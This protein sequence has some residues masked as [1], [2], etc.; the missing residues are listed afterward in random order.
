MAHHAEL[1]RSCL[2]AIGTHSIL[3]VGAYAGDLTRV[4]ADWAAHS[5]ARV[6]AV[7][8]S[9]QPGL[10]KLAEHHPGVELVRQTSLQA[11]PTVELPDVAVIDGDHNYYTVS[12]ELRILGERAPGAQLPLL[13]FHDVC[14]PHG[15]RDDYFD[16]DAIPAEFRRPLVGEERG[17]FPGDPGTRQGGL[18]YPRSAA[19]EGGERNGVLTA[20][21]DFVA[22]DPDLRLVV[23]P[24]FFGFGAVWNTGSPWASR[25]QEILQPWDR[26]PL[27]E[28]ME[29]NR[30]RHIAE[31]FALQT[32]L[33]QARERQS[34]RDALLQRLLRSSAFGLAE[35]LSDLRTRVG[36]APG[37]ASVSREQIRSLLSE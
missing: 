24:A 9:P 35:H 10:V 36:I 32:A 8:P 1:I 28:R 11:L 2:E 7:D 31:G 19:Q 22:G 25:V 13:L 17:I 30:I 34:R 5:G 26:H 3:E 15:R 37:D 23:V 27:L 18:P 6:L 20:V 21:E 16:P 12:Q 14:W 4:L 33:W 29:K